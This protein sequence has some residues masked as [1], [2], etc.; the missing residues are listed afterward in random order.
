[1]A[2]VSGCSR[3]VR[4]GAG[5]SVVGSVQ[6]G[7]VARWRWHRRSG[8]GQPRLDMECQS[9]YKNYMSIDIS[10]PRSAVS[11][12]IRLIV[13]VLTL[14]LAGRAMTL[15]Y[16]ARAGGGGPGDPSLGWLM[17]LVGDAVVGIS[18]L[19]VAYI[20]WKRTGLWAW[21]TVVVW[22]SL[23][24]WDALSAFVVSLTVPWPSFFMLEVFGSSMF[25]AA[26]AMHVACIV[27]VARPAVRRSFF[28]S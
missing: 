3:G 6:A 10:T 15:M 23:A 12:R 22:N 8:R 17:P 11:H 21:V 24:V 26:S 27:L 9:T 7:A 5:V 1:M 14:M 4:R 19:A 2:P 20:V 16:I 25:F 13:A 18:A 28:G